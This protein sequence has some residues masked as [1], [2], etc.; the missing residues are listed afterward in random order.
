MEKYKNPMISYWKDPKQK[1]TIKLDPCEDKERARMY[2]VQVR[3]EA[4]G[5][6]IHARGCDVADREKAEDI[7]RLTANPAVEAD[8]VQA[9][10]DYFAKDKK[11]REQFIDAYKL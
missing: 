3:L 11:V 8:Y 4:N 10:K 2:W 6:F 5:S 9:L 7:L 1:K